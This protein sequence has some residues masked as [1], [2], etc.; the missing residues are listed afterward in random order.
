MRAKGTCIVGIACKNV[1]H[2]GC[3]S[4]ASIG[5]AK[6][7]MIAPKIVRVGDLLVGICGA[8]R[9]RDVVEYTTPPDRSEIVGDREFLVRSYIP[10][11]RAALKDAGALTS[12]DGTECMDAD[13]MIG[14]RGTLYTLLGDFCLLSAGA[15]AVG[16][17][18]EYAL[19]S[20]YSTSGDPA[21]RIRKALQA[22]SE[23]SRS[24]GPPYHM[25]KL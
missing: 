1:V 15:W 22:A 23:Y 12:E 18:S 3:D 6:M 21:K 5:D 11:L 10:Q 9:V 8:V 7:P 16:S 20:L 25:F 4:M 14:Y 2:M 24:C 17:G 13:I 19:G